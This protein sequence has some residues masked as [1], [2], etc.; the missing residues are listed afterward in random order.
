MVDHILGGMPRFTWLHWPIFLFMMNY[1]VKEDIKPNEKFSP[2]KVESDKGPEPREERPPDLPTGPSEG[3]VSE[4]PPSAESTTEPAGESAPEPGISETPAETPL[5]PEGGEISVKPESIPETAPESEFKPET[6]PETEPVKE[7]SPEIDLETEPRLE[8]ESKPELGAEPK[9]GVSSE[10]EPEV[11]PEIKA[12]D[13]LKAR[14]SPIKKFLPLIGIGLLILILIFVLL[15]FISIFRGIGGAKEVS[16]TYW[17]LWESESVLESIINDFQREFPHIK[18][19]YSQQFHKDYRE[20]LQSALARGEGPDIFRFHNT[21]L[22]MFRNELSSVPPEVFDSATYEATFYPVVKKDL[23]HEGSYFGV[24]LMFDG[25]ALFVNSEIFETAGKTPP[26][27]WDDLRKTAIELTVY[28][29]DGQIKTAG[30]AL[31]ETSNV[32]HWSDILGLMMF[33]NGADLVNPT[34]DLAED[35]LTFYTLFSTTDRV[36]DK[37]LPSSTYAFATGKVAMYFGPSWRIFNIK[38]INPN[39]QFEVFPV[40]QLPGTKI[41]WA[42]YWVEGVSQKSEHPKEAW[43]FLKFLSKKETM[44]KFYT[45]QSKVRLFGEIPSRVDLANLYLSNPYVGPF[46]EQASYAQ[47]WYLSSRTWDNGLNEKVIKYFENAVNA[48]LEGETANKSLQTAA[49]GVSQILSQYR[50]SY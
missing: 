44:Q 26:E 45:E 48:V 42:T 31:G 46:L 37:T 36:W 13:F 40:P 21:W 10:V 35:A 3:P 49:Q 33:Q 22:P 30:A 50:V 8:V 34:D 28:D 15:K 12:K 38:E 25:L 14:E 6:A 11:A 17:G 5:T 18:I 2:D 16:L 27:T 29:S 32:D 1:M 23:R 9:E 24:P 39:L 4:L 43:E 19:E 7:P 41:S 20:R 47:S